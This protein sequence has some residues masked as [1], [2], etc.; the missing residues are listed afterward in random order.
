M[1]R[2]FLLTTTLLCLCVTQVR[3]YDFVVGGIYYNKLTTNTV[4]VTYKEENI[5]SYSGSITI[6]S[7][8]AYNG[9]T[10]SVTSIGDYAFDGCSSLT[11]VTIPSSVTSIG[12]RAFQGCSGLT[13]VTIPNSVT[14]IGNNT[15]RNCSG[16]T[17]VKVASGNPVYDSRDN[18]NAIIETATNTLISG[19][20]STVIPNSVTSIGNDAFSACSGLTSVTIPNNVTSIGI[21][22]FSGCSSLTSVTIPNSVTSIGSG[23][24]SGCSGLTSVRISALEAWCNIAFSTSDA[25]PLSFAHHLILNGTEVSNLVIPS[26]LNTIKANTFSGC[27]GLTSVNI[28]NSVTSIGS[29]AFSGCSGLTYVTIPNSV[30]SIGSGAFSGCSGLTSVTIPNS[31]TSIGN[32]AFSRCI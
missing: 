16:L 31:V 30:T 5:Q 8:V 9:V 1:K 20:K 27:S 4:A 3:A 6:P 28:P 21:Y 19:C 7:T 14:S 25:N 12:N 10:Y 24:F 13:S 22:A 23:A 18:C 29:A 32:W 15:F 17:S 11:S 26:S 2:F